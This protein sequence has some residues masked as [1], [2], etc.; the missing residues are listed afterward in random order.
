MEGGCCP[1]D[2]R[3]NGPGCSET[4]VP[5]L[6]LGSQSE[7][8]SLILRVLRHAKDAMIESGHRVAPQVLSATRLSRSPLKQVSSRGTCSQVVPSPYR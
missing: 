4:S 3:C 6:A 2:F 5:R 8:W 1:H 7:N